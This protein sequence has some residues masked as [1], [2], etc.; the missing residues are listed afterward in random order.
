MELS[1][2]QSSQTHKDAAATLWLTYNGRRGSAYTP[3]ESSRVPRVLPSQV[4]MM[5]AS[6][7]SDSNDR[8][9][10]KKDVEKFILLVQ[11]HEAI[12]DA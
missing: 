5:H 10:R 12:Y 11:D 1:P 2:F 9:G 3:A 7:S 8:A 4:M 6:F